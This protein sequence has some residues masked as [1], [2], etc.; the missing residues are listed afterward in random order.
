MTLAAN[1]GTDD[2]GGRGPAQARP[3]AGA[4]GGR[5][6]QNSARYHPLRDSQ[7]AGARGPPRRRGAIGLKDDR[8]HTVFERTGGGGCAVA[9]ADRP[10][11]RRAPAGPR[12]HGR[13]L[14][15]PRRAPRPSGRA[16]S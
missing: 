4:A 5:R 13:R 3:Q 6:G 15:G 1:F 9:G 2:P 14:R 12:R 10:L 8:T 7:L 11:P 16:Q